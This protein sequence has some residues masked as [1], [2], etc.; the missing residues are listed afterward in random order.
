MTNGLLAVVGPA[1]IGLLGTV[2]GLWIGHRRWYAEHRLAKR[3]AFD[4][5]RYD[6]YQKL[7]EVVESAHIKI[8]V[9]LPTKLQMEELQR[10]INVFRMRNAILIDQPD[11][12]LA[13]E[14]FRCAMQLG[15]AIAEHGSKE[16]LSDY[17]T[18]RSDLGPDAQRVNE[19]A[20]ASTKLTTVRNQLIS[21]VKAVLLETS[22][23]VKP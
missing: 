5:S 19:L 16:F 22:Y 3:R 11:S 13:E 20:E 8:R 23:A 7:W 21:R 4:A 6:A 14:Y 12:E 1:I 2:L 10:G 9:E 18:T 17:N 15:N